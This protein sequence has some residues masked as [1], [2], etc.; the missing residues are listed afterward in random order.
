MTDD[1]DIEKTDKAFRNN[2]KSKRASIITCDP[3]SISLV[4]NHLKF[5]HLIMSYRWNYFQEIWTVE[6]DEKLKELVSQHGMGW[7]KI[8]EVFGERN[9]KQCRERWYNHLDPA[10]NKGEWTLEVS[11]G[12]EFASHR[13]LLW[14]RSQNTDLKIVIYYTFHDRYCRRIMFSSLCRRRS[15]ITGR[16]WFYNAS[17]LKAWNYFKLF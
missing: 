2:I 13:R 1:G 5:S 11:F 4:S 16:R 3:P 9:G 12:W 7:T 17:F 6:Q 8:G 15:A 10:V 14:L